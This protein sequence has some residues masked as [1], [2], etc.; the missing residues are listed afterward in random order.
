VWPPEV[1]E[2]PLLAVLASWA[3]AWPLQLLQWEESSAEEE[4]VQAYALGE[5]V[6]WQLLSRQHSMVCH[7]E[8]GLNCLGASLY[9]PVQA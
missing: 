5:K 6:G 8:C 9:T 2:L 1:L 7:S 4:V 3:P